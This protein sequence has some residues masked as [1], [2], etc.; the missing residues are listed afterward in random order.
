MTDC[1]FTVDEDLVFKADFGSPDSKALAQGFNDYG[2]RRNENDDGELES[3]DVIFEAMEPGPPEDRNGVRITDDFLRNLASKDY[4]DDPPTLMDH[5]HET[6]SKI[7]NL[8][9]VWFSDSASKLMVMNR[10]YNTGA[11][12]HDEV[13]KRFTNDPPTITDGSI[14]LGEN[15]EVVPNEKGEPELKDGKIQEFSTTPMPGGYDEGGLRASWANKVADKMSEFDEQMGEGEEPDM[16]NL[17]KIY[18][19]YMS[20]LNMT[21]EQMQMWDEHPCSDEGVD[22]GDERRS[23]FMMLKGQPMEQWDKQNVQIANRTIA[24]I[25]E[26]TEM[27]PENPESG[28]PGTCPSRWATKLLNRGYNPFD[29]FPSGNPQ[30]SKETK[31]ID[32]FDDESQSS[33]NLDFAVDKYNISL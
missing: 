13:I 12:T 3:I 31:S 9:R 16:D 15:Y 25:G 32:K 28:G 27:D 1:K 21:E 2:V 20:M 17:S 26:Q 24:F 19:E 29:S 6:L 10:I 11:E 7:G 14:G 8:T 18:D 22:N 5:S 33:E 4:S 23:E 30:F